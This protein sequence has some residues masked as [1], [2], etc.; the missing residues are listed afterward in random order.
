MN[1]LHWVASPP[2]GPLTRDPYLVWSAQ[3][4]WRGM[5]RGQGSKSAAPPD[6][7]CA[8]VQADKKGLTSALLK[9]FNPEVEVP[10]PYK[11]TKKP[12]GTP[13]QYFTVR[14][15]F[16]KLAD[17]EAIAQAHKLRWEL[18]TPFRSARETARA[19][20]PRIFGEARDARSFESAQPSGAPKVA[21]S[22]PLLDTA[23]AVI[24]HGF[25]L[26]HQA[27]TQPGSKLSR[28]AR[29][30]I[31][32]VWDQDDSCRAHER[33]WQAVPALGYGRVLAKTQ[34]DALLALRD[35]GQDET[36]LYKGLD[37]LIDY[38][39][40][41]RR[42]WQQ[43]HGA[44]VADVACGSPDP[45]TGAIDEAADAPLLFVQLPA[46]T[47]ADASGSSLGAQVLDALHWCR[48]QM[49]HGAP[50]V[51]N[52]S[53]G[54]TACDRRG[55]SLIEQA[56]DELLEAVPSM[57]LVLAAGNS[58]DV[59]CVATRSVEPGKDVRLSLRLAEG[60]RTDT[61]VE[62][63]YEPPDGAALQLR[64]RPPGGEWCPWV[65]TDAQWQ[66]L[67]RAPSGRPALAS[68][69]HRT[70]VPLSK[71]RSM[72]LLALAPSSA[73]HDDSGP[74]APAGL[75]DVELRALGSAIQVDAC[76]EW[77][78]ISELTPEGERT[79]WLEQRQIDLD[80]SLGSLCYGERTLVVGACRQTDGEELPYSSRSLKLKRPALLAASEFSE[81]QPGLYAAGVREGSRFLAGGTSNAAAM[82][83]RRLYNLLR[84]RFKG[85]DSAK[86]TQTL[87]RLVK[88]DPALRKA[89]R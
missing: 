12:N 84:T 6:K 7:L 64:V 67:E 20:A 2:H 89:Q 57:A 61:F 39:D 11:T 62:F 41:R 66:L 37:L 22:E 54:T 79:A 40:A 58:R 49:K 5:R 83:T 29:T 85:W 43:T 36:E 81:S 78:E 18:A 35:Q 82:V 32:C 1:P 59:G 72:A 14:F 34:I 68:L 31:A 13:W 23:I 15:P 55:G 88:A 27:F 38:S 4:D 86:Q 16:S 26:L 56:I 8:L 10:E 76:L 9:A 75:W 87:D 71:T 42:L 3:S 80:E 30:R 73:S 52:L 25:P 33:W 24:D 19:A 17:F 51:V 65:E 69:I 50:L 46:S 70:Q 45:A 47:A 77:D 48:L 21:N 63:W 44:H 60:D 53:Y 74:F 28:S